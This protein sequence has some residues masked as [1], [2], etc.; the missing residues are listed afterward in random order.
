MR[1]IAGLVSRLAG[2]RLGA[3]RALR[4]RRI[5]SVF[6]LI[7]TLGLIGAGCAH[8]PPPVMPWQRE[9]LAKRAL[10]FDMDPVEMRFRQHMWGSREGSD[11]GFGQ[12]GGG[13]GCN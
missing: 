1:T 6:F 10:R 4:S 11:L 2:V 7:V 12:P 13:C 9:N 3:A 5:G 8:R